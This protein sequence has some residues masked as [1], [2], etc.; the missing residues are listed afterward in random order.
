MYK[1][2]FQVNN[3][4][5]VFFHSLKYNPIPNIKSTVPDLK[6]FRTKL[7][8]NDILAISDYQQRLD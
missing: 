3:W 8:L 1:Y 2:I 7:R 5:S 4:F 6:T